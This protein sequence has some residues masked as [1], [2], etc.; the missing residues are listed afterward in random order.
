M[1]YILMYLLIYI[2]TSE[3]YIYQE[4]KREKEIDSCQSEREQE[5]GLHTLATQSDQLSELKGG[6]GE[7]KCRNT[8]LRTLK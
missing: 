7:K 3:H 4:R 2:H 1:S 5:C 8:N 6:R